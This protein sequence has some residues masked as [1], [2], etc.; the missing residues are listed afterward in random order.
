MD[1]KESRLKCPKC[2]AQTENG[3]I[4]VR[5][6]GAAIFWSISDRTRFFSRKDLTQLDLGHLSR[7]PVGA[8]AVIPAFRCNQCGMAMFDTK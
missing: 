3:F 7:P 2:N 5:G 1:Q 6:L 4:Y 8:Q